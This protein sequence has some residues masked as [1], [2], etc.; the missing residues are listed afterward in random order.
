MTISTCNHFM[1]REE[2][3]V[4]GLKKF[5]HRL[6]SRLETQNI[7]L[8]GNNPW[9]PVIHNPDFYARIAAEG[10]L[11]LGE[12]YMDCWWD[13]ERLDEFFNRVLQTNLDDM[14]GSR[15]GLALAHLAARLFNRQTRDRSREVGERHYD[16]G[17]GLYRRMLDKRMTYS[18]G[19]WKDAATLDEAQ[20]AKLDLACR[21][22]RIEPGMRILDIG[23]G[24][25]GTA[26]YA[27]EKYGA[28]VTGVT[29]SREQA[30]MGQ[31]KCRHLPVDI[32]LMDYRDVDVK[33]TFDRI[34]SIGMFE[35]V[36][37]KNYRTFMKNIR[38]LLA[39]DG[40]CLLQTIG[41]NRTVH[42]TDPWINKYIFP[43]SM[44]PSLSQIGRASEGLLIM[45]DWHNFGPDYEKTLMEWYRNFQ[46]AWDELKSRYDKRFYRMWTYYLLSC[47]GSFRARRNQLWQIVFSVNGLKGGYR[48]V[49]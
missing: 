32:R 14:I 29:V 34:I 10:S 7:R 18:C 44:L 39:D 20:E 12:S 27:A 37:Y 24:W 33:E 11:G 3:V 23:C 9:D 38:D 41:G 1:P 5:W 46:S 4:F 36:G 30:E 49:R 2:P 26:A 28:S 17:N 16:I 22:L 35:H 15:L 43:N 42:D 21:K 25:G 19:Y 47:A 45:E 8:N 40:L 13:C 48:A 6:L 31:H